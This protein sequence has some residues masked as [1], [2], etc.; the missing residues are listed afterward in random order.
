[1]SMSVV[2]SM[3][4]SLIG[5]AI[6]DGHIRSIDDMITRYLPELSGTSYD[7]V[8]IRNL[9]QM[10]SGVKWDETY[11]DPRSDRRQMLEVQQARDPV[12]F[13]R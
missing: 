8:S 1:M 3:I 11:T 12:V 5:A 10:A 9:L 7:G 13:W 4:A 2:K 6:K